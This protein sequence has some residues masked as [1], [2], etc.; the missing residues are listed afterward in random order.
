MSRRWVVAGAVG[1]WLVASAAAAREV[2]HGGGVMLDAAGS[3]RTIAAGTGGT[4]DR[5]FRDAIAAT[6]PSS[7]CVTAAR[8]ADCPAFDVIGEDDVW[9]TLTRAR[10]DLGVIGPGGLSARVVYD[11]EVLLGVLE[12]LERTFRQGFE[13]EPFVVLDDDIATFDLGGDASGRWRHRLYRA[14]V[15]WESEHLDATVGRQRIPWGVGRLWNPI[16]RLN[17][18]GPLA[19]EADESIG[20]DALDVRWLWSGF[21]YLEAVYAPQGRSADADYALRLHGIARDV[22]YSLLA[23]VFEEAR[24]AGLD[25]AGNLGG[26]A[27]RLEAVFSDPERDVWPVGAARPHELGQF[28][29]VVTSVDYN[30]DVGTGLYVLVEHLYNGNGLGFGRGRAGPLLPFFE[31]TTEV[32]AGLPA[33]VAPGLEGP[34]VR[35]ANADL[36]GGSRVV[37]LSEQLTGLLASYEPLTALTTELLAIHDWEGHSVAV[38]PIVRWSPLGSLELTLGGQL[39]A[40]PRRSEYGDRDPL[41]YAIVE[42]FY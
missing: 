33:G 5:R 26:A 16:D 9:Q 22:D 2:W 4:T 3:V 8:F 21:S 27:A 1:I 40:G 19:I 20:I 7:V 25:L 12:V 42:W 13:T 28:W 10:A 41:G 31:S 36:F 32:P 29:Q 24:T 34:F 38:S 37:T 35:T 15:H 6:L 11:Q 18:I 17:P 14:F 39:F 23:G 30:V